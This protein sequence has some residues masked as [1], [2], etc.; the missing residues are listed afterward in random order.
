MESQH[1]GSCSQGRG[2]F[3]LFFSALY[4]R[5]LSDCGTERLLSAGGLVHVHLLSSWATTGYIYII[6]MDIWI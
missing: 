5:G 6:Y 2:V 4:T 1:K 3:P